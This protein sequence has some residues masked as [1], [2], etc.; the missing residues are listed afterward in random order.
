MRMVGERRGIK[1]RLIWK[2]PLS[3]PIL[4]V[5]HSLFLLGDYKL[6]VSPTGD[7]TRVL[8][9]YQ[10]CLLTRHKYHFNSYFIVST[11]NK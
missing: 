6:L 7:K 11:R 9:N 2:G 4:P 1:K 10:G 3:L 8:W 5:C